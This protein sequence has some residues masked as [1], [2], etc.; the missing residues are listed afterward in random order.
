[1]T[2]YKLAEVVPHPKRVCGI[3]AHTQI[4]ERKLEEFKRSTVTTVEKMLHIVEEMRTEDNASFRDWAVDELQL[5]IDDI[6]RIDPFQS[7]DQRFIF[8]LNC[9]VQ[10]VAVA[11][12]A[13]NISP[14]LKNIR[15]N[16]DLLHTHDLSPI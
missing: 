15:M 1:M 2:E 8:E 16:Y 12:Q 6:H 10:F 9:R 11:A 7:R 5:V 13:I 14:A 4:A 3:A